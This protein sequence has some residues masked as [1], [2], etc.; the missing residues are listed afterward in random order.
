MAVERVITGDEIL[1]IIVAEGFFLQ[2]VVDV[3]TVI[4]EPDVFGPR[5]R[6]GLPV[7]EKKDVCLDAIGVKDAGR[8]AQDCV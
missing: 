7:V 3:G 5:V 8:Q 1:Q 2:C 4:V 6:A